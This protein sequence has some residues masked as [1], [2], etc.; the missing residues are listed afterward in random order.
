[1][2]DPARPSLLAYDLDGDRYRLLA[3]VRAEEPFETDDPFPV[4]IV[5]TELLGRHAG[6]VAR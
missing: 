6:T 3:R 5:L 1:V 4:R 2:L